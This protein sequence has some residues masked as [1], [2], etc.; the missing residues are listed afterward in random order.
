[1]CKTGWDGEPVPISLHT[2]D[3]PEDGSR[4]IRSDRIGGSGKGVRAV[5]SRS[6]HNTDGSACDGDV[7]SSDG[8]RAGDGQSSRCARIAGTYRGVRE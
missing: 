8:S 6:Y 2:H 7:R 3:S 4:H 5:L 1:V